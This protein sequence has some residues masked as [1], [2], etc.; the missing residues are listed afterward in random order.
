VKSD[1][2]CRT[3]DELL[4]GVMDALWFGRRSKKIVAAITDAIRAAATP[5]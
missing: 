5:V 3:E 1:N 2:L 4:K